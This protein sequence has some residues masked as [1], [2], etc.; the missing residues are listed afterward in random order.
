MGT[1]ARRDTPGV[2][3]HNAG[4]QRGA[5][6]RGQA[7]LPNLYCNKFRAWNRLSCISNLRIRTRS[8]LA[9]QK[10]TGQKSV[11][12][13]IQNTVLGS[14]TGRAGYHV[15]CRNDYLLGQ[16]CGPAFVGTKAGPRAPEP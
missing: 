14:L 4:P 8:G 7:P 3:V 12:H 15:L 11:G 1:F 16:R 10:D 5:K 13:N 6:L 2:R 9:N